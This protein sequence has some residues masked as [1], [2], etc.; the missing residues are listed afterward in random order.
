[1][2]KLE[3]LTP[4]N[5]LS[6]CDVAFDIQEKLQMVSSDSVKIPII[7]NVVRFP[8]LFPAVSSKHMD[9]Y[10]DARASALSY[11]KDNNYILDYSFEGGEL[12]EWETEVNVSVDRE[13]FEQFY[14]H[15]IS[16]YDKR[17][18]EPNKTQAQIEAERE[19]EKLKDLE[20]QIK[21]IQKNPEKFRK[22]AKENAKGKREELKKIYSEIDYTSKAERK[23]WEKKWNVLQAIW[24]AYIS[25]N[26]INTIS[27][28]AERLTM[29]INISD[30]E[31][32][33]IL[34]GL[35]E[36]EDCIG[37]WYKKYNSYFF[38]LNNYNDQLTNTYNKTKLVYEKFAEEY[39]K[40]HIT[41]ENKDDKISYQ[42]NPYHIPTG[43]L[44]IKGFSEIIFT[45]I[46][47]VIINYFY[48]IKNIDTNYKTYKDFNSFVK[49]ENTNINSDE[50]SKKIN[51]INNRVGKETKNL[52]KE[53][54]V[55][56]ENKKQ[57]ANIYKWNDTFF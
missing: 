16:V 36:K 44:K 54:I 38:V 49:P 10:G 30:A 28:P 25:A 21:D 46:P 1:M 17:V 4:Y 6:V 34:K 31:C 13:K 40:S 23:G 26:R 22:K 35:Q 53:I 39:R 20:E 12:H 15:L 27:I 37:H 42:Y 5:F 18:V 14:N 55:K 19:L 33:D 51:E 11:L 47:A 7:R 32:Q 52:I 24:S 56:G 3:D 29:G 2:T 9:N 43:K 50:F 8:L 45:K 57:E 41:N 48:S